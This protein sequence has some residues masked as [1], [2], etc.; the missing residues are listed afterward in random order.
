MAQA[1]SFLVMF[2][3]ALLG[4]GK[5][6]S[7]A[8]P[9]AAA[10]ALRPRDCPDK[11]GNVTVP[12]PF[13]IGPGCSL[14]PSFDLNCSDGV[15][16]TGNIQIESITLETA[17]IVAYLTSTYACNGQGNRSQTRAMSFRLGSGLFLLSPADNVFTAIGCSLV[18]RLN[19][20]TGSADRYLTGCITTCTSV[21]L[22]DIGQEGA[23]CS[24]QGCCQASIAPGLRS[25]ASR[26]DKDKQDNNPVPDNTCQ[27]AFVAKKGWY[28]PDQMIYYFSRFHHIYRAYAVN[29]E[30]VVITIS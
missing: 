22:D 3:I 8:S 28:V 30:T 4:I 9:P 26:W 2:Y 25:V 12:Y 19:G 11:C 6:V 21:D 29:L 10:V 1:T 13:G 24:G 15:L 18:A 23:P 20:R 7:G 5:G 16:L 17:Q 27:Y 14:E